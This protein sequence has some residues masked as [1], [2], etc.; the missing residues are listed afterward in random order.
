MAVLKFTGFIIL[1]Y[2]TIFANAGN[3]FCKTAAQKLADLKALIE[4]MDCSGADTTHSILFFLLNFRYYCKPLAI[5]MG[6]YTLHRGYYMAAR[7][8]EI[9][10]RVC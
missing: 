3:K 4:D 8:Y 1:V 2:F 6:L 10:L 5:L 9:P 7:R